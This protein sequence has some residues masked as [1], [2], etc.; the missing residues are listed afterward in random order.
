MIKVVVVVVAS[1][2]PPILYPTVG[3]VSVDLLV[4]L[5]H[6]NVFYWSRIL[7]FISSCFAP[8]F[9][10]CRWLL[11]TSAHSRTKKRRQ[12]WWWTAAT[13]TTQKSQGKAKVQLINDA[14]RQL[15]PKWT[16]IP[17]RHNC[18]SRR[19]KKVLYIVC[20][21]R[22]HTWGCLESIRKLNIYEPHF[23]SAAAASWHEAYYWFSLD[24]FSSWCEFFFFFFFVSMKILPAETNLFFMWLY[25]T[26]AAY[27]AQLFI[28]IFN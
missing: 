8:G 24:L 13:T 19:K 9:C 25:A 10:T 5:L 18:G 27:D 11:H 6:F 1:Q 28:N 14:I 21:L 26:R 12:W 20:M 4:L 3:V 16:V 17:F 2:H 15:F 7:V 23:L 22:H